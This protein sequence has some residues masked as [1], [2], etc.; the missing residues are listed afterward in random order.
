MGVDFLVCNRCGDTFPDCG[1]YVRCDCYMKWC[2]Q[3]CADEEGFTDG[4]DED[5]DEENDVEPE[6]SCSFCRLEE[7]SDDH[8]L[9][10]ALDALGMTR[11]Q[12]LEKWKEYMNREET[13]VEQ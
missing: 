6:T 13:D 8:L 9:G 11:A 7:T 1:D 2:S 3:Y 10:F 4:Y 5:E 12:L